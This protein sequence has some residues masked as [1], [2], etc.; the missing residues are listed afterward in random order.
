MVDNVS[1]AE[2]RAE[3]LLAA[4]RMVPWPLLGRLAGCLAE[5]RDRRWE[6]WK[7][8][9]ESFRNAVAAWPTEALELW[10]GDCKWA[11]AK[12]R[13]AWERR[14]LKIAREELEDRRR[15]GSDGQAA[16]RVVGL[17][18]AGGDAQGGRSLPG[19][20][21]Q[22]WLWYLDE[23][24]YA[25]ECDVP[26]VWFGHGGASAEDYAA[27]TPPVVVKVAADFPLKEARRYLLDLL[28]HELPGPE[29][30]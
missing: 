7:A 11:T 28:S 21:R 20:G 5:E 18:T 1:I 29:L 22:V 3:A 9:P 24:I 30:S 25:D 26:L 15:R 17:V 27:S 13:P 12:G 19:A 6:Q 23:P 4:L 16:G 10:F 14:M 2:A 8:D